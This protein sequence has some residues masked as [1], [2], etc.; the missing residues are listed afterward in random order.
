MQAEL[1]RIREFEISAIRMQEAD[2]YRAKM[3]EY[4]EELEKN[5]MEKLNRLRERE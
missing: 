1:T 5:Y 2:T 3:Q 4:R